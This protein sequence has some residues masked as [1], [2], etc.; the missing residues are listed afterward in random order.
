MSSHYTD[1]DNK[2][3]PRPTLSGALRPTLSGA[4]N[5]D[6]SLLEIRRPAVDMIYGF[7]VY[8]IMMPMEDY[9]PVS[10]SDKHKK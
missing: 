9:R 1:T 8:A 2:K 4:L 10:Y 3:L 7:P 5:Q 6:G